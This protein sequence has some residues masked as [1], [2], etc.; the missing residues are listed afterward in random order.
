MR[1]VLPSAFLAFCALASHAGSTENASMRRANAYGS[2]DKWWKCNVDPGK[3]CETGPLDKL[4]LTPEEQAYARGVLDRIPW[5]PRKATRKEV[6]DVI[7]TEARDVFAKQL[8]TGAGPGSDANRGV[9]VYH[10]EG[11]V[12]MIHWLQPGRFLLVKHHPDPY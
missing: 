9:S 4:G 11:Y 3:G 12:S 8:F 7:G 5:H 10:F 6:A 1:S 2:D